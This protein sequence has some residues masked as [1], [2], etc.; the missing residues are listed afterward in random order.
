MELLSL[1]D[2]P[3]APCFLLRTEEVTLLLDCGLDQGPSLAF[4]PTE[5]GGSTA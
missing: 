4:L 5:E 1:S 3:G 2:S